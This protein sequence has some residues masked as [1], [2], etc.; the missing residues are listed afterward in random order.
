MSNSF[1]ILVKTYWQRWVFKIKET[2]TELPFFWFLSIVL[3]GF[4]IFVIISTPSLTPIRIAIVL[5]VMAAH[6]FMYWFNIALNM[7]LTRELIVYFGIQLFLAASITWLTNNSYMMLPALI[8]TLIGQTSGFAIPLRRKLMIISSLI[9]L[10]FSAIWIIEPGIFIDPTMIVVSIGMVIVFQLVFTGVYNQTATAKQQAEEALEKL[11]IANIKIEQMT[12]DEER[13]RIA[14]E[15]HDTLAQGLTGIILQLDAADHYLNKGDAVK[16]QEVVQ[17]SMQ[18]ARETLA[19]SRLVIDDLHLI[20]S[21]FTLQEH[22]TKII[23]N[24]KTN[25]VLDCIVP[26]NI[27]EKEHL[28]IEKLISEAVMNINKHAQ[29]K[30]AS[31]RITNHADEIHI[32]IKDDGIGFDIEKQKYQSGHYGLLGMQERIASVN[33]KMSIQTNPNAGCEINISLQRNKD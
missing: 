5:C 21:E 1:V 25:F 29:A 6:I 33:G 27:S 7:Q 18:A 26:E 9:L 17:H 15:L 31:I 28:L 32:H 16:A 2:H 12:R 20:K 13:Q 30:N 24:T 19:E 4:L 11:E 23:S 22:I 10:L 3:T 14:R 8:M